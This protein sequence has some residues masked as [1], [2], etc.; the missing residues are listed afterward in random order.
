MQTTSTVRALDVGYGNTKFTTGSAGRRVDCQHFPSIAPLA[1]PRHLTEALG[2]TRRTIELEIDGVRYE[3]GPDAALAQGAFSA[4]NMDDDFC[5][6]AEYLALVRGALHF[7]EVD[8]IDL[9]V[10]GLPV[11]TVERKRSYLERR[12]TGQHPLDGGRAVAI[13]C[14]KVL[15]QPRGALLSYASASGRRGFIRE[16]KS[17]IIDCGART[18]D[19]LVVDGFKVND[20]CSGAV[21]RGMHDVLTA[22]AEGIDRAFC[23]RFTDFERI[24]RAL[25]GTLKLQVF[26]RMED[27]GPH[28]AAARK[29]AS[30]AVTAMRRQVQDASDVDNIV[31]SGGGADFFSAA[32]QAAF[33]RHAVQRLPDCMYANVRGFQL[34]GEQYIQDASRRTVQSVGV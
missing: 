4:R 34:A 12:L 30:D 29:I 1:S 6:T 31:V 17:L 20:K 26:G 2:S 11:S 3:V 7:M 8:R 23:T 10:V 13:Q 22:I 32:I 27:L 14:V 25:R 18:F 19:W 21:N 33:P 15:A 16:Q 28:L 24:E 9:L 5:M